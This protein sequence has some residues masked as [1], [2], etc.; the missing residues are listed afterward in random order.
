MG[1][2]LQGSKWFVW[3]EGLEGPLDCC[4]FI[5]GEGNIVKLMIKVSAEIKTSQGKSW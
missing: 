2:F 1:I 4:Y 3:M 5:F